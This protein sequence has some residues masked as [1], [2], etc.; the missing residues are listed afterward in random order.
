MTWVK[1]QAS[2]D[3]DTGTAYLGKLAARAENIAQKERIM[4]TQEER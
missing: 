4:G 1:P 3:D 2:A